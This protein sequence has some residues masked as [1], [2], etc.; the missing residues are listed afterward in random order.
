MTS[1]KNI[2]ASAPANVMLM[3][4]HA[5]L[6][7]HRAIVCALSQRLSVTLTPRNDNKVII[8]SA[9]GDYE[10]DLSTIFALSVFPKAL[11]FV[12]ASVAAVKP[13]KGFSLTIE[14]VFSHTVGLGS[15]AAITAACTHALL[16]FRDGITSAKRTFSTG[17]EVIQAVQGRG[18]G[19]DLAASI[20]GGVVGYTAFPRNIKRLLSAESQCLPS[21]DLFYCGYKTPTPDVL[22]IVSEKSLA[23][24]EIYTSLYKQMHHVSTVA[25]QA[26]IAQQWEKLGQLMNI[27]H[28]LMDA[29]GV[30]DQTLSDLVYRQ[31]SKANV[32]GAKISGS[33]LGDCIISLSAP[34]IRE[35]ETNNS[36]INATL[37]PQGVIIHG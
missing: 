9:L 4:E 18:S 36:H 11:S 12:L 30:S 23:F 1:P 33:G 10:G 8:T 15:S 2:T 5:V 6:F 21:L 37:E 34:G 22:R 35:T 31:R 29:I 16:Y 14:S 19:S 13:T 7:G 32:L 25:E 20:Y 17:Y 27:Y 28:G 26:I 3:G 24:P